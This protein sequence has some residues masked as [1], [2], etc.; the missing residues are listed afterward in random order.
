MSKSVRLTRDIPT[1]GGTWKSGTVV[2]IVSITIR[3]T[4]GRGV[5]G[6]TDFS[7]LEPVGVLQQIQQQPPT[8]QPPARPP[9]TA[10]DLDI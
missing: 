4:S 1:L 6:L 5:C 3:D 2:E 8:P 9:I 10:A 7:A